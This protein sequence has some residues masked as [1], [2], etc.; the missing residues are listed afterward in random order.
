MESPAQ[1]VSKWFP[2][3]VC[4]T[5]LWVKSLL[6]MRL[7]DLSLDLLIH[8]ILER[9]EGENSWPETTSTGAPTVCH[10]IL[11]TEEIKE[12]QKTFI[13]LLMEIISR[14]HDIGLV[15]EILESMFVFV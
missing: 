6:A 10:K 1:S 12:K 4:G 5:V 13:F 11:K 14:G 2:H 7:L 3:T 15:C 8:E 9:S